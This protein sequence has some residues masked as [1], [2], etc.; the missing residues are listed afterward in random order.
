MRGGGLTDLLVACSGEPIP[1]RCP[2]ESPI[3]TNT[4]RTVCAEGM[5]VVK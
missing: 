3:S 5:S 1:F 4:I 2:K